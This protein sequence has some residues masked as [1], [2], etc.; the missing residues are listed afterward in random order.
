MIS[1]ETICFWHSLVARFHTG[2]VAHRFL[3]YWWRR[4]DAI[5]GLPAPSKPT[6][7]LPRGLSYS[8]LMRLRPR[9]ETRVLRARP[10]QPSTPTSQLSA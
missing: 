2:R 5:P 1:D 7:P 6:Q 8:A 4:G 9:H 3:V 10:A